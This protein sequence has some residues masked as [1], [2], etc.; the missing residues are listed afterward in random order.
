MS[1]IQKRWLLVGG[2]GLVVIISAIIIWLLW[3]KP[4]EPVLSLKYSPREK[5]TIDTVIEFSCSASLPGV[6]TRS[7][8][9]QWDFGDG[10]SGTGKQ[11]THQYEEE[12][13]YNVTCTAEITDRSGKTYIASQ[14][15]TVSVE[16]PPLPE[17]IA[18]FDYSPS[19]PSTNKPVVFDA[20]PSHPATPFSPSIKPQWEYTWYIG[21][22]SLTGQQVE[23][24]FKRP[25]KELPVTLAVRVRDQ[26]GRT[27]KWARAEKKISVTV[28]PES[29]TVTSKPNGPNEEY[30]FIA[31]KPVEFAAAVSK[32]V[33]DSNLTFQWD[34]NN[35]G[36][37]EINGP[38]R[39]IS[40]D[41]IKEG[42]YTVVVRIPELGLEK[43]LE[44]VV[45][46]APP[47]PQPPFGPFVASGGMGVISQLQL[48]NVAVGYQINNDFSALLGYGAN[49]NTAELDRTKDYPE[50]TKGFSNQAH[51]KTRIE[52]ATIISTGIYYRAYQDSIYVGGGVGY[53][54]LAGEHRSDNPR[55][56]IQGE[57]VVP[58]KV[59]TIVLTFG[60]AYKVGFALISLQVGYV[61]D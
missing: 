29:V 13:T 3:P 24:Q 34:F 4:I 7:V 48:W 50:V 8:Q 49:I 14:N 41:F 33:D 15:T 59:N 5:I 28:P 12:G 56:L 1:S 11:V 52:S 39:V 16:L 57:Q 54:M 38:A 35:D 32:E 17:L 45:K 23:H 60:V 20:S 21:D 2:L 55:V 40:W 31:G 6:P 53:L 18:E 43:I 46:A 10:S 47:P 27:T 22:I 30:K 42:T 9:C 25:V 51:I 37:T 61:L 44:V 36:I 58:F 19:Q 26:F